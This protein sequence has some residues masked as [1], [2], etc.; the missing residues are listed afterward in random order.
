MQKTLSQKPLPL[1][2]DVLSASMKFTLHMMCLFATVVFLWTYFSQL[3]E[4]TRT[5]RAAVVPSRQTQWIQSLEGGL[6]KNIFVQE[7]QTVAQGEVLAEIDD[8]WALS[9]LE[10]NALQIHALTVRCLRLMAEMQSMSFEIA[11]SFRE[12]YPKAVENE[13]RIYA[14]RKKEYD[15]KI[16]SFTHELSQIDQQILQEQSENHYAQKSYE[17]KMQEYTLMESLLETSAISPQEWLQAQ[18]ILGDCQGMVEQSAHKIQRSLE[19]RHVLE[20]RRDEYRAQWDK[21]IASEYARMQ[22]DLQQLEEEHRTLKDK[23]R[24]TQLRAPVAGIINKA[25]LHTS[26]GVLR[27][28]ETLFDLVPLDDRLMIEAKIHP[29]DIGFIHKGMKAHVKVTAFDFCLY[30]GLEGIVEHISPDVLMERDMPFYLVR[31]R[32]DKN[33]LERNGEQ[34]PII[35]GMMAS[36]DVLTGHRTVLQYLMKPILKSKQIVMT[37][38]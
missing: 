30:G 11:D 25:Y 9:Q 37:E 26:G 27:P 34:Y 33:Y 24:R 16:L 20:N 28:G 29:K 10:K 6:M 21:D 38:R 4:L 22:L 23:E 12:A 7:G 19:Y 3:E 17:Y 14:S 5:D 15:L 8:L 36:V 35:P 32:T 18:R 1:F 31:V 2:D 13:E